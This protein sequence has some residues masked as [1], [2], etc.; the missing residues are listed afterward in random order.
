[1]FFAGNTPKRGFSTR[2]CKESARMASLTI[3]SAAERTLVSGSLPALASSKAPPVGSDPRTRGVEL[4]AAG[5]ALAMLGLAVIGAM[6]SAVQAKALASASVDIVSFAWYVDVDGD[7]ADGDGSVGNPPDPNPDPQDRILTTGPLG[8]VSF[9]TENRGGSETI[10]YNN[11]FAGGRS[12]GASSVD[13]SLTAASCTGAGCNGPQD[14]NPLPSPPPFTTGD[15]VNAYTSFSG[16]YSAFPGLQPGLQPGLTGGVRAD[17]SLPSPDSAGNLEA[18]TSSV[19]TVRGRSSS[20]LSTYFRVEFAA[21]ALAWSETPDDS[22]EAE[23]DFT[24]AFI[25]GGY[26]VGWEIAKLVSSGGSLVT[27]T[28]VLYSFQN[29]N[30]PSNFILN[31]NAEYTLTVEISARVAAV[32]PSQTVPVPGVLWLLGVGMIPVLILRAAHRRG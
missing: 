10:D 22:A 26:D 9:E 21:Q 15:Y 29:P 19:L 7:G 27:G 3:S 17:T 18:A 16:L 1:M 30:A 5:L 13:P 28:Q 2:K 31:N 11:V 20:P 12:L 14:F 24:L 6:P 4:P 32:T 8:N 25:G 23:L